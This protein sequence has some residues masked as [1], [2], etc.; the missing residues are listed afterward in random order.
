MANKPYD[1]FVLGNEIKDQF[2]S[3]LNH[4][5]FCK[6]DRDLVGT[7]GMEKHIHRYFGQVGTDATASGAE[8]LAVGAGNTKSIEA[9]FTEEIYKIKLVQ[10]NGVWHDEDEMKDPYIPFTISKKV[11]TDLFNKLN[12]DIV[13]EF[14]KATI[15]TV[16]T[17]TDFFGAIVETQ[18]QMKTDFTED[19]ST[20]NGM[21]LLVNPKNYAKLRKALG[22]NLKYV[23]SFSRVGYVGTV[24]GAN[25]FVSNACPDG[26]AYL[27]TNE[28][29]TVFYKAMDKAELVDEGNRA[30]DEANT[31]KNT[32]YGRAYYVAA[33][34]DATKAAKLTIA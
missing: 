33:L 13:G 6:A 34:T 8:E 30:G 2:I 29:V 3:H 24:A 31:R 14:G 23:E 11:G 1:N 4:S 18:A 16:V 7:V 12:A 17:G 32:L 25:V 22:E 28:A 26:E 19:P 20:G 21:F 27:A 10:A 9:S 15:T 5:M